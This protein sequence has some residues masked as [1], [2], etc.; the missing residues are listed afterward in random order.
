M[1]KIIISS[2]ARVNCGFERANWGFARVVWVFALVICASGL[3]VSCSESEENASADEYKNWQARND[4]YFASVR[5]RALDA[6][7]LAKI[8]YGDN[9]EQ[10]CDW[11]AFLSYSREEK[12]DSNESTDSIFVQIV[13]RGTGSGY[14]LG[15]DNIRVFYLGR[16]MPTDLHP[17][18]KMFDHSGQSTIVDKIFDRNTARP[19]DFSVASLTRGF[20]TAV[21]HMRI[22]DRWKIYVPYKLGYGKTKTG[23][24][25]A[26]ST[27]VFEVEL[28]QYARSGSVLP[29]WN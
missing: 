28:V 6:I 23:T 21:Q 24:I 2:T 16:L 3:L 25:P 8:A 11:R 27:L 18:G 17:L 1:N 26:Y 10:R 15:T 14:P 9:W 13:Q 20:A 22:G 19:S 5:S 12:A 29:S 4:S 7:A